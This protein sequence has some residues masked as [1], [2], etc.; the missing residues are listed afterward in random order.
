MMKKIFKVTIYVILII[1]TIA[2]G[3]VIY[4]S[5]KSTKE[6]PKR[7]KLVKVAYQHEIMR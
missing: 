6:K 5:N 4:S 2:I 3:V 1:A 7:A